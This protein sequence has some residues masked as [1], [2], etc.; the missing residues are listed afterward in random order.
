MNNWKVEFRD[1]CKTCGGD[2]PNS[3]FRTFCSTKCRRISNNKKQA[4]YNVAWQKKKRDEIASEPSIEKVQC[5]ICGNWYAK[6]CL[7]ARQIHGMTSI[8]YKEKFGL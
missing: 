1:N 3:R 8:E 7:H 4:K 6:V 5:A 2:L